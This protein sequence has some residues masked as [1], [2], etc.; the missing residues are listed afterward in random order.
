MYFWQD[1]ELNVLYK[2]VCKQIDVYNFTFDLNWLYLNDKIVK[3][4]I[5]PVDFKRSGISDFW[6]YLIFETYGRKKLI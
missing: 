4:R 6:L 2:I 3:I 5:K 1:D